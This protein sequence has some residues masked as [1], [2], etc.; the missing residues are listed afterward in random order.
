VLT[1]DCC[2]QL[3]SV[4][5]TRLD[6]AHVEPALQRRGLP[7]VVVSWRRTVV[8]RAAASTYVARLACA[9]RVKALP[10]TSAASSKTVCSAE[11]WSTPRRSP[12][13]V[14]PSAV[15][16]NATGAAAVPPPLLPVPLRPC[17]VPERC[18]H[19][20]TRSWR[21]SDRAVLLRPSAVS[22]VPRRRAATRTIR[23]AVSWMPSP[24]WYLDCIGRTATSS[25]H[26]TG[27]QSLS[28]LCLRRHLGRWA[29]KRRTT[30]ARRCQWY[31]S[32]GAVSCRYAV[33]TVTVTV[34]VAR[35][36][37][38]VTRLLQSNITKSPNRPNYN[39]SCVPVTE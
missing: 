12:A 37:S 21:L 6:G 30:T 29:V 25:R 5:A 28:C 8:A 20:E 7:E 16:W 14:R 17:C 2:I 19:D 18:G 35:G 10:A 23:L 39:C 31:S 26:P 1:A 27:R 32:R 11:L 33:L 36:H 4:S 15:R 24:T 34:P 38:S 13:P 9:P 22:P 3:T